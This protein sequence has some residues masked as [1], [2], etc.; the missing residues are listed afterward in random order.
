MA[1]DIQQDTPQVD[2]PVDQVDQTPEKSRTQEQFEKLTESNQELKQ[3]NEQ[4][5]EE[6]QKYQSV[7]DSLTPPVVPQ[8]QASQYANLNQE[9]I[10]AT[11]AA[12]QDE[13]GYIDGGKL[14]ATLK[15]LDEKARNAE[16]RAQRVE[17]HVQR[18]ES[19]ETQSKKTQVTKEV[20]SKFPELDPESEV[21]NP[22]LWDTVRNEMIGQA[23]EGKEDFMAAANK[24]YTKFYGN[25]M[26]KQ[27]KQQKE[28]KETQKAQINASRP[29]SN[30]V[31]GYY[32]GDAEKALID[33]VRLGK[34]GALAEMLRRRGQ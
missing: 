32:E 7:L 26:T 9:D 3:E 10:D 19:A 33:K 25:E 1:D 22:D 24:W 27:Q 8:P 12:M 29:T 16:M 21:F 14:L 13:N 30:S 4:L 2:I 31:A 18:V 5:K 17:E 34:K 28:E 15:S 6:T 20:H 11:F 23:M